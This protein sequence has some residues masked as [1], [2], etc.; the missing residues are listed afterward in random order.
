MKRDSIAV[1]SRFT[2][3]YRP[4]GRRNADNNLMIRE[5]LRENNIR[6]WQLADLMGI[7]EETLSRMLRHELPTS[8][9]MEIVKLIRKDG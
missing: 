7:R 3:C 5:A 8:E 6:Q 4:S 9:Q 1:D 2:E